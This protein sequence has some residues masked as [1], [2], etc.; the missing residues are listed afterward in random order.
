MPYT[1]QVTID[2]AEP[3]SLADWWADA[4]G[5]AV[6]AQDP[7]FIRKMIAEGYASDGDTTVHNGELV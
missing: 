4:L 2:C 7:D 5:W 1:F 3:H 6:S